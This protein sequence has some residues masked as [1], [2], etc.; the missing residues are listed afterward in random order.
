MWK[1]LFFVGLFLLI[2]GV[3][4][5]NSAPVSN[6]TVCTCRP[7]DIC[8]VTGGC[9]PGEKCTHV[10]PSICNCKAAPQDCA[11]GD[12]DGDGSNTC[13]GN[14]CDSTGCGIGF[15]CVDG[16]CKADSSCVGDIIDVPYEGPG[17]KS[18]R[19]LIGRLFNI[20]LPAALVFGIIM[21]IKAGYVIMTSE[22]NPQKVKEGQEDLTNAVLGTVFVALSG[23]ILRLIINQ[24]LGGSVQF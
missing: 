13:S 15:G 11:P 8:G 23:V 7:T 6:A 1:R 24:I 3:V 22:G 4:A 18:M 20:F 19:S 14:G 5:N 16:F 10:A 2:F 12:G 21:I 9:S 17:I